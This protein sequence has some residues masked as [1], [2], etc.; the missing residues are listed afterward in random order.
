MT[1]GQLQIDFYSRLSGAYPK[2]E[3]QSFFSWLAECYLGYTRFDV[4][5]KKDEMVAAHVLAKFLSATDQLLQNEPIQYIVGATEFYGLHLKVTPATLIPRPETEE[6]VA[7]VLQGM[8]EGKN[9]ELIDIGTGSGCIAIALAKFAEGVKVSGLDVSEE[10]LRVATENAALNGVEVD[11]F[12]QDVLKS[13][14]LPKSYDVIISNPPYV[15]AL[16]K[17]YM[18][19]NVTQH[20]PHKAL[21][22]TNEDPLLFYREIARMAQNHLKTNGILYFEINEY[23]SKEMQEL[24]ETLGFTDIELKKDHFDKFRMLKCKRCT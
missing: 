9:L 7:W 24:L 22:V 5:L 17:E 12:Q 11:F 1:V 2:E 13:K 14:Q 3:I 10:A 15:R 8:G 16:E 4:S 18:Q 23:L 6:L 19:P 20:E 21:Y